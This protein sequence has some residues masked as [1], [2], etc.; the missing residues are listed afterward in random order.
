MLRTLSLVTVGKKQDQVAGLLPFAFGTCDEIVDDNLGPVG[1]IAEL[2][3]PYHKAQGAGDTVAEFK[4]K[5]AGLGK[6]A[7]KHL[8]LRLVWADVLQRHI[9]LARFQVAENQVSLAEGAARGI[10]P[11]ESDRSA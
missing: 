10:L 5:D 7:V 11:T 2:S 1:E 6:G 3:F 9:L 4:P 8:E